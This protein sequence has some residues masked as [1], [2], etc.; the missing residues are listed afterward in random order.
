MKVRFLGVFGYHGAPNENRATC[1]VSV[2]ELDIILD[3][4]TGL[5]RLKPGELK[6]DIH[7]LLSHYH[8][9]HMFGAY[10]LHSLSGDKG[11]RIHFYGRNVESSVRDFYSPPRSPPIDVHNFTP[12]FHEI[13]NTVFDINGARIESRRFPHKETSVLGFRIENQGKS[14]VYLTDTFGN[15]DEEDFIRNCDLLIRDAYY[16]KQDIKK[17]ISEGHGVASRVADTAKKAGVKHLCL[18]H[19]PPEAELSKL[20]D[21]QAEAEENFPNVHLPINLQEAEI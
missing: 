8:Y 14:L 17:A 20:A 3:A 19:L 18:Y 9:D 5:W 13:E 4:G 12:V 7:L 15:G 21:L 1:C 11:K 2:P 10:E 16:T 6:Q